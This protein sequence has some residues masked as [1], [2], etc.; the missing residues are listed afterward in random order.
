M[1]VLYLICKCKI[2]L[3][4]DRSCFF[5]DINDES[6][7]GFF[8]MSRHF[9]GLWFLDELLATLIYELVNSFK[10]PVLLVKP[11]SLLFHPATVV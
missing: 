8:H 1:G 2:R 3:G 5:C 6:C 4:I 11:Y 7:F 10:T 9:S